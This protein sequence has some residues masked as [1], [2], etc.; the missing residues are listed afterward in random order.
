MKSDMGI[1]IGRILSSKR[2]KKNDSKEVELTICSPTDRLQE[3]TLKIEKQANIQT[4]ESLF[5]QLGISYNNES[6]ES[7]VDKIGQ[8]LSESGKHHVVV[9]DEPRYKKDW[10][11][12]KRYPNVD[13]VVTGDNSSDVLH[14]VIREISGKALLDR[15]KVGSTI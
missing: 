8:A 14:H 1:E 10:R 13:M 5:H 7:I 2:R 3:N 9:V 11:K 6:P 15:G 4:V 12:I